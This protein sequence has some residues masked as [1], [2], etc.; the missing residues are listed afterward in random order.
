ML[1]TLLRRVS[2]NT[3]VQKVTARSFSSCCDSSKN[4]T[5]VAT[6]SMSSCC[7]KGGQLARAKQFHTK[8]SDIVEEDEKMIFGTHPELEEVFAQNREFAAQKMKDFPE[9][10]QRSGNQQLPKYLYIGCSDARMNANQILGF[11][12]D[13]VFVT[14]NIGNQVIPNDLSILAVL[15]FS[16]GVLGIP[17]VILCGHTQCGAVKGALAKNSTGGLGVLEHWL[18][19]LRDIARIHDD[20]L[21]AIKD[22][23]QKETR[24]AEINVQE[25]CLNLFKTP[26]IQKLRS[27]SF[28]EGKTPYALP[29]I[30]GVF[31]D[32][33][34]GSLRKLDLPFKQELPKLRNIY[35]LYKLN[36]ASPPPKPEFW[37]NVPDETKHKI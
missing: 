7:E 9:Y 22:Q 4:V 36:D 8:I 33:F 35:D 3:G 10:F 34:D 2:K 27:K 1:S 5:N 26:I 15:E 18:T 16:L 6:R 23:Y 19:P 13:E 14:R 21:S 17:H 28:V 24:L 20:E 29:R 37:D 31:Y 30:H 32:V 25:Q 11:E 12:H